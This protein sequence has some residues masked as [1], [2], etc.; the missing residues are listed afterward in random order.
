[1][2]NIEKY[3]S[4]KI[5]TNEKKLARS[6]K[7][8]LKVGEYI[9]SF[10]EK[11]D[12]EMSQPTYVGMAVLDI[13]KW[14]MV[15]RWYNQFK[16]K[17]SN[18]LYMDTDSYIVKSPQK[19]DISSSLS[20]EFKNELDE[21]HIERHFIG[22]RPKLYGNKTSTGSTDVRCKGVKTTTRYF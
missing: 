7:E 19:L 16:P 13:S 1:M 11:T 18:L 9:V 15:D 22:I 6:S 12:L 10:P 2:E 5:S 3:S 21:G 8:P 17:Q 4:C 20:G 14:L